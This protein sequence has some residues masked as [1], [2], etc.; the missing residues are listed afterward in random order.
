M[1]PSGE[2]RA[3]VSGSQEEGLH[4]ADGRPPVVDGGAK[5]P[6]PV[7]LPITAVA[8]IVFGIAWLVVYY[9]S[10]PAVPGR[11]PGSYWNLAVGFGCMV[12]VAG[13]SLPLALTVGG[14]GP[15]RGNVLAR[16]VATVHARC[17]YAHAAVG[18]RFR[19]TAA[20]SP[21]TARC[22]VTSLR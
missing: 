19:L 7:W 15:P 11:V 9:L 18:V 2:R 3:E 22:T 21:V 6:S 14:P 4:P 5:K 1:L 17:P 16:L 13:H 20:R 8:L 12:A 10:E